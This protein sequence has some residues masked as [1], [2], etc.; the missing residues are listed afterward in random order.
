MPQV[1]LGHVVDLIKPVT[2]M[3]PAPIWQQKCH[4]LFYDIIQKWAIQAKSHII[5]YDIKKHDLLFIQWQLS[6]PSTL[7]PLRIR[8]PGWVKSAHPWIPWTAP[9]LATWSWTHHRTTAPNPGVMMAAAGKTP[10]YGWWCLADPCRMLR[11]FGKD[12]IML[13]VWNGRALYSKMSWDLSDDDFP[14]QIV[15]RLGVS[16][17]WGQTHDANWTLHHLPFCDPWLGIHLL[18]PVFLY[19]FA[20]DYSDWVKFW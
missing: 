11:A 12:V 19:L 14:I 1:Q 16:L 6:L 10:R 18:N 15:D 7:V 17:F 9:C 5:G 4:V 3:I 8:I 13:W 20:C 2:I